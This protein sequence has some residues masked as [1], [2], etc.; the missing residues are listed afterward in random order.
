MIIEM[1]WEEGYN[2]GKILEKN[3]LSSETV[4]QLKVTE[5]PK[6]DI[7]C[8]MEQVFIEDNGVDDSDKLENLDSNAMGVKTSG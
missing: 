8:A 5:I 4:M 3:W 1:W 6:G 7:V 2:V